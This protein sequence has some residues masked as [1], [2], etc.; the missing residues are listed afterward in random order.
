MITVERPRPKIKYSPNIEEIDVA[1]T[2]EEYSEE[3]LAELEEIAERTSRQIAR[4][5]KKPVSS[6]ELALILGVNLK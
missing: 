3:F 6:E 1:E 4:G 5:E 2:D